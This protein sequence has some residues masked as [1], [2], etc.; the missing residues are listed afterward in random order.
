[1]HVRTCGVHPSHPTVCAKLFEYL[2]R[3]YKDDFHEVYS[4]TDQVQ[5]SM[6]VNQF[7]TS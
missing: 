3:T 1:M 5:C 4:K 2:I 7:Y 6:S